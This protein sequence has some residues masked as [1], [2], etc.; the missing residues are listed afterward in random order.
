MKIIAERTERNKRLEERRTE[1][2]RQKLPEY[3]KLERKLADN[4]SAAAKN[5]ADK[6][7]RDISVLKRVIDDNRVIVKDMNALLEAHGYPADYLDPIYTCPKCRDKGN[8]GSE[9]CKCLLK[10][11]N[12]LAAAELNENAPL[13]KCRFDNFRLDIYSDK[14]DDDISSRDI[15]ESNL[16]A[17]KKF[18]ESF[19]GT[20]KG[21]LMVGNTGLG[22]THLSLS[23]AN[24]LI[25][26]GFCVLYSSAN[27]LI[28][29]INKEQFEGQ[30]GDTL[31]LA[32]DCD[33]L[34]L[35]DLGVEK[36]T[37]WSSSLLYEI[38]NTRQ[39]RRAPIIA[40]TN[41]DL[42]ELKEK[43]KDR[44]SSRLF[45]MK[46]MFFEGSDNRVNLSEN[47]TD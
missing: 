36:V 39:N 35:D 41:L 23:I 19:D 28:R 12:E 47:F 4:M 30:D 1:E 13:D 15:V 5:V 44:I 17:C 3:V 40:N 11:I 22:K 46:I 6:E 24:V 18:A 25:P 34:I 43:Y 10:I 20:G 42:D 7:K 16:N 21:I 26:R 45:S 2:I 9:W 31:S 8:T 29:K 14:G 27:E 38:I 32:K 33:L 37:E